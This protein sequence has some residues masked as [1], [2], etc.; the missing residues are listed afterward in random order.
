M[1]SNNNGTMKVIRF[2]E[3]TS[4]IVDGKYLYEKCFMSKFFDT[5]KL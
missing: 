1:N 5:T 4:K 3:E 2:F